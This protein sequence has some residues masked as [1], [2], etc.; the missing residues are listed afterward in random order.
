[1]GGEDATRVRLT[2][3]DLLGREVATLVDE[4]RMPGTHRVSFDAS[5]LASGMYLYRLHAGGTV[6]TKKLVL[7]R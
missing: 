6:L 7:V 5:R 3:C 1:M 2:V 4:S